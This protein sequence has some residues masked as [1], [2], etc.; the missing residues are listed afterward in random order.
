LWVEAWAGGN[1]VRISDGLFNVL[2]GSLQPIPQN[3]IAGNNNLWLGVKVGSDAEM[4]PRVQLGSVPFATQALTVPDGSISKIKL[5]SD[6]NL[7]P[8]EESITT[9]MLANAAVT[10]EKISPSALIVKQT[11]SAPATFIQSATNFWC[12]SAEVTFDAPFPTKTLLVTTW[13]NVQGTFYGM[14]VAQPYVL[15][16]DG[17]SWNSCFYYPSTVTSVNVGY[18]AVG[19]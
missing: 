15:K 3:I 12:A 6:V 19:Y 5:A 17:F 8:G 11:R 9:A 18:N 4:S 10:G 7:V 13:V 2:L 14:P 1:S 16:K